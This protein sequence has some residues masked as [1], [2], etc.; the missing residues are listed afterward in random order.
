MESITLR[1]AGKAKLENN[2]PD[3]PNIRKAKDFLKELVAGC[4]VTN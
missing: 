2:V 3:G 1:G 4:I